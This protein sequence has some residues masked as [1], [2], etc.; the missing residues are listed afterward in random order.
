MR[1]YEG[2]EPYIFVSYAHMDSHIVVPVIR[3][4]QSRG[5]RVWYDSGI[6]AG[7]EWP[8]YIAERLENATV[9]LVFMS[10]AAQASRNCRDEINYSLELNKDMLVAY[11]EDTVLK[12]GMRL[13]LSSTQALYRSR[14]ASNDSFAEELCCSKLMQP[15]KG[16]ENAPETVDVP[17]WK[18]LPSEITS[19]GNAN[20][21]ASKYPEAAACYQRAADA[22]DP[23][24]QAGLAKCLYFGKGIPQDQKRAY[25]MARPLAERGVPAAECLMGVCYY[26]GKVASRDYTQSAFWLQRAVDHGDIPA[27]ANLGLL[28]RNGYGVPKDEKKSVELYRRGVER[29]DAQAYSGLSLCYMNGQ[30]VPADPAEAVRLC[31]KAAEMGNRYALYNMGLWYKQGKGVPKDIEEAIR[32]FRLAEEAGNPNAKTQLEQLQAEKVR[33][34]EKEEI[35]WSASGVGTVAEKSHRYKPGRLYVCPTC[36]YA[37]QGEHMND[38][39]QCPICATHGRRFLEF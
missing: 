10:D 34:V 37:S 9:V 2:R 15:C 13:R 7:S 38:A 24:G 14:H 5:F 29:E 35:P 36:G 1:V 25:E 30:G 17:L 19:L 18:M 21:D 33:S 8:E 16:R 4:I 26:E 27:L 22:G 3:E 11:I 32:W 20:F 12:G 39:F 23:F 31:R 28:Y 6:E